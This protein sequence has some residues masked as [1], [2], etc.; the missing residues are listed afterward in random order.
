M[1]ANPR[2]TQGHQTGGVPKPPEERRNK[3]QPK[4][5]EW[6]DLPEEGTFKLILPKLPPKMPDGVAWPK[7]TKEAYAAWREDP[8]S[9]QLS[10]ADI[11]YVLETAV[12][13]AYWTVDPLKYE[14]HLT[15]RLDHLGYNPKAKRDLRYRIPVFREAQ[16]KAEDKKKA[17]KTNTARRARL[18]LVE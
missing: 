12:I 16:E 10:V 15:A 2:P 9:S 13:H 18:E 5:G 14:K 4:R 17:R 1:M 6:I 11:K 3:A 7:Q 8:A